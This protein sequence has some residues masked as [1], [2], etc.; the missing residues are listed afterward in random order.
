MWTQIH[1]NH[2]GTKHISYRYYILYVS[3]YVFRAIFVPV[4]VESNKNQQQSDLQGL[5]STQN[6]E[7]IFGDGTVW[8]WYIW[9]KL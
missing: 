1:W 7:I 5:L 6:E 2:L 8:Q 3:F 4:T 9:P